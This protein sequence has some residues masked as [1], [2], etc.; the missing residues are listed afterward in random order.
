M[1]EQNNYSFFEKTPKII[2]AAPMNGPITPN[3]GL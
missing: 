3:E 1:Q 2:K